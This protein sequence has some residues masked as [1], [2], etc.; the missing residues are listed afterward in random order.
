M[1]EKNENLFHRYIYI[2]HLSL[3][4]CFRLNFRIWWRQISHLEGVI[5]LRI[6]DTRSRA[7]N[8]KQTGS[9]ML[10]S[11]YKSVRSIFLPFSTLLLSFPFLFAWIQLEPRLKSWRARNFL[12]FLAMRQEFHRFPSLSSSKAF[13]LLEMHCWWL[14]RRLRFRK[15]NGIPEPT[16]NRFP[17]RWIQ[18]PFL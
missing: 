8:G 5:N 18:R 14:C 13:S 10:S 15:R 17:H 2:S 7:K 16:E 9:T 1:E 3:D 12:F 11:L 6:I 4:P